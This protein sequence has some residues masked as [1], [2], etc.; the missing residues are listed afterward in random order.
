MKLALLLIFCLTLTL[1]VF[2]QT[3]SYAPKVVTREMVINGLTTLSN[4][5]IQ[6]R[7]AITKMKS[8]SK[9]AL[10]H[11][12]L[13][14]QAGQIT[15]EQYNQFYISSLR[16]YEPVIEYDAKRIY[17]LQGQIGLIKERYV[18]LLDSTNAPTITTVH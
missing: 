15:N 9:S 16:T 8:E 13:L 11:E 6:L 4:Q 12:I 2:G 18:L 1:T 3:N 5:V 7:L 14:R 17:A 10:Q